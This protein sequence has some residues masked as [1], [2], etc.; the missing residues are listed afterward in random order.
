MHRRSETF[1]LALL[2]AYIESAAPQ[3]PVCSPQSPC[4]RSKLGAMEAL[5]A[6]SSNSI[7]KDDEKACSECASSPRRQ[8]LMG[9]LEDGITQEALEDLKDLK[10]AETA[11]KR[12]FHDK[13]GRHIVG[14]DARQSRKKFWKRLTG[15]THER[16]TWA[17]S[18]KNALKSSCELRLVLPPF[19]QANP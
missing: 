8:T 12:H 17:A 3:L 9:R 6:S 2:P 10:E 11:I 19:C 7:A 15:K 16:V 4:A 5:H 1:G 18:A 14:Q 13:V